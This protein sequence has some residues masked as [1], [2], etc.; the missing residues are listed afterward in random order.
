MFSSSKN[1]LHI[2][3]EPC[4]TMRAFCVVTK[5]KV[6]L[7]VCCH[8]RLGITMAFKIFH[9]NSSVIGRWSWAP[10]YTKYCVDKGTRYKWPFQ[11]IRWLDCAKISCRGGISWCTLICHIW[12]HYPTY[13]IWSILEAHIVHSDCRKGIQ[14]FLNGRDGSMVLCWGWHC[15]T[16]QLLCKSCF[17]VREQLMLLFLPLRKRHFW[18]ILNDAQLLHP[19]ESFK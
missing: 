8:V 11:L 5:E 2:W 6:I 15:S 4:L 18:F 10:H 14:D 16:F 3:L 12:M 17:V 19:T 13:S 1:K 9:I 7:A